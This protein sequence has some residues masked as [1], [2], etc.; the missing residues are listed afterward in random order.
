[1]NLGNLNKILCFLKYG[2]GGCREER[3]ERKGR[4]EMKEKK[5]KEGNDEGKKEEKEPVTGH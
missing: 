2:G 1:M 3:R 5:G 4:E